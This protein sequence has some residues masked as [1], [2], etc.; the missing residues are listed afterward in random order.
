MRQEPNIQYLSGWDS[1]LK[2]VGA[3]LVYG[4]LTAIPFPLQDKHKKSFTRL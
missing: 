4:C 1:I 3:N 2:L